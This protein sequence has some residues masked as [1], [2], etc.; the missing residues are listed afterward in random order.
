MP[1]EFRP[2]GAGTKGYWNDREVAEDKLLGQVGIYSSGNTVIRLAEETVDGRYVVTKSWSQQV[3][4]VPGDVAEPHPRVA[5]VSEEV[6]SGRP[7]YCCCPS[8]LV[9]RPAKTGEPDR[10]EPSPCHT[11]RLWIASAQQTWPKEVPGP[12]DP[13]HK[14]TPPPLTEFL[15]K[16]AVMERS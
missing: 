16:A 7:G 14:A 1:T 12:D 9:V 4:I 8:H 6:C 15:Q 3:G 13:E 5:R 2:D 10:P 11:A